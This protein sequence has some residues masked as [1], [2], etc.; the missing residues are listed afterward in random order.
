MKHFLPSSV[1]LMP[2]VVKHYSEE[3][4][5]E[6]VSCDP[7]DAQNAESEL[8]LSTDHQASVKKNAAEKQPKKE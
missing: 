5:D 2:F 7:C 6:E 3:N 1:M 4:D 8:D